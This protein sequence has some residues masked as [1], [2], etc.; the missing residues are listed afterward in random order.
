MAKRKTGFGGALVAE[1]KGSVSITALEKQ[2]SS[3]KYNKERRI[4]IIIIIN[5]KKPLKFDR[6]GC[7]VSRL[8]KFSPNRKKYISICIK[9]KKEIIQQQSSKINKI[10]SPRTVQK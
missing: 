9:K 1:N 4:I 2:I 5:L 3:N 8:I 6:L 10:K 7:H